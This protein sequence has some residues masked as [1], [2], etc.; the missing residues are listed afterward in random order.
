MKTKSISENKDFIELA[1]NHKYIVYETCNSKGT[2]FLGKFTSWCIAKRKSFLSDTEERKKQGGKTFIIKSILESNSNP[3]Y[4]DQCEYYCITTLHNEIDE[5]VNADNESLFYTEKED[6][7][8]A[9][10]QEFI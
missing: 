1:T 3:Q 6:E 2:V 8:K 10:I 4:K 5:I 7:L 9:L